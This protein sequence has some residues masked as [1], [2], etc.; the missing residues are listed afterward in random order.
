MGWSYYGTAQ[1]RPLQRRQPKSRLSVSNANQQVGVY[2]CGRVSQMTGEILKSLK[3]IQAGPV[4]LIS[5]WILNEARSVAQAM[6]YG[7]PRL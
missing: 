5:G 1:A 3:R 4:T 2:F 7:N 6:P